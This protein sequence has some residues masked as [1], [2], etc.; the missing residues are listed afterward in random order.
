MQRIKSFRVRLLI[1]RLVG[2]KLAPLAQC[3]CASFMD[4]HANLIALLLLSVSIC[5]C[6]TTVVLSKSHGR[7]FRCLLGCSNVLS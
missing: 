3:D 6:L 1:R 7:S 4:T 2:A 5:V